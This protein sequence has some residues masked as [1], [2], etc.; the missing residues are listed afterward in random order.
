MNPLGDSPMRYQPCGDD[1]GR[2]GYKEAKLQYER[3]YHTARIVNWLIVPALIVGGIAGY[4]LRGCIDDRVQEQSQ[5]FLQE[6]SQ[7]HQVPIME[8][9]G[10][11]E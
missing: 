1:T 10:D 3:K 7:S 6:E 4:Y 5:I 2:I 9:K 11:A 8:Y